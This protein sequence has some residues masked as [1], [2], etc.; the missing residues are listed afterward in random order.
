MTKI[1]G[2]IAA[3]IGKYV[4]Q[5]VAIFGVATAAIITLV[6]AF[7]FAMSNLMLEVV[8][9][10]H[11]MVR[12]GVSVLPASI[13]SYWALIVS[14]LALRWAFDQNMLLIKMA[15]RSSN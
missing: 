11:P 9:T 3:Y 1:L 13:G 12:V 8:P 14:S 15:H 7:S 6:A 4:G 10:L 2:I 5:R